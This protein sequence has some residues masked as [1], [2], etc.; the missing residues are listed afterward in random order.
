MFMY[1]DKSNINRTLLFMSQSPGPLVQPL[2]I[3]GELPTGFLGKTPVLLLVLEVRN[4][5]K[6]R[7]SV[8]L[9]HLV[10]EI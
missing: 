6:T 2:S 9:D 10:D 5:K 3:A 1:I 7:E 8:A 4:L